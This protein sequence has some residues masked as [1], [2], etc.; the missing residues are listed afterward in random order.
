[1]RTGQLAALAG[2]TV[3]TLRHYHQI[4]ILPEPERGENG[5]RSYGLRD[6]TRVLRLKSLSSAGVPL[7]EAA[8]VL[9]GSVADDDLDD[10]LE[11]ID[12]ELARK[13]EDLLA[14]RALIAK[15]RAAP[16]APDLPASIDPVLELVG[17]TRTAL[18]GALH[19]QFVL[20]GHLMRGSDGPKVE[21][22]FQELRSA[23]LLPAVLRAGERFEALTATSGDDAVALVVEDLTTVAAHF[24]RTVVPAGQAGLLGADAHALLDAYRRDALNETQRR[25]LAQLE[26]LHGSSPAIPGSP[27]SA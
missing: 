11:T 5:Y 18:D 27:G 24:A 16:T 22:L 21:A 6:L 14:Q 26:T 15:A 8:T 12:H 25:I 10:L 13:V 9:D 3:R 2:V 4:G 7:A 17:Q 1:M 20:L 19:E 23:E